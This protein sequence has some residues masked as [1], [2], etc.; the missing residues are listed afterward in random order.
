M[1]VP[2]DAFSVRAFGPACPGPWSPNDVSGCARGTSS[3][4]YRRV[5]VVSGANPDPATASGAKPSSTVRLAS[6]GAV[7]AAANA[8]SLRTRPRC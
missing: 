3:A 8:A 5:A 1:G 6:N 7:P 4:E 2:G